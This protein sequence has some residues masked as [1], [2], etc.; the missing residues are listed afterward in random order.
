[1]LRIFPCR[2]ARVCFQAFPRR[3]HGTNFIRAEAFVIHS[4]PSVGAAISLGHFSLLVLCVWEGVCGVSFLRVLELMST[5]FGV[6]A[7]L[8]SV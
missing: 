7:V 1:M 6:G 3:Y 5:G 2:T 4:D 8:L